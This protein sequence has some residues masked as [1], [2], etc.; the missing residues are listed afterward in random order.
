MTHSHKILIIA[1]SA[2]DMGNG[3]GET[4]LWLEELTTPYYAFLD[5]GAEV[6]V[7]SIKGGEIPIDARSLSDEDEKPASVRRYEADETFQ[8]AMKSSACFSRLPA[9]EYDAIFLPGG[10]GTMF[11]Y[12]DSRALA[13]LVTETLESGRVVAAVCHGPAGLVSALNSDGTPVVQGRRVTGF[14]DT[15]EKAVGLD[16]A[17]PFLLETRLRELGADFVK[18]DDFA[19]HAVRDSTLVT[20]QNPASAGRAAE[21]VMEVLAER[22]SA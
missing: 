17:V 12:P 7:A 22:V 20:G 16:G 18:A 1:T 4:G 11:D 13:G 2:R 3:Q 10:H 6:T 14:T 9:T 19:V 21:L 15:E 5:A 8:R